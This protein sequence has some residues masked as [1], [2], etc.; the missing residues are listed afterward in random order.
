M[1]LAAIERALLRPF[2]LELRSVQ[3]CVW[4][5]GAGGPL[6]WVARR[7]W[8]KPVDPG[9]LD[10]AVGG[11]IAG[12]DDA[13]ATLLR[14]CREEAGLDEAIARGARPA[15]SLELRYATDFDGLPA[16]HREHVT[17]YELELPP[18]CVPVPAD[19]EHESIEPMTPAEAL[20]SIEAGG[21]TREGAQATLDLILRRGWMP[22]PGA[23]PR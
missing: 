3:A 13:L 23:A 21:W 11:G 17:L 8:S 1:P 14:E 16:L 19:G 22:A 7:A 4:T 2:G 18:G 20:A 12:L 5:A 6:I 15:G 10:A 9:R